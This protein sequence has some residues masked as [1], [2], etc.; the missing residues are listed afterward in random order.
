MYLGTQFIG[1]RIESEVRME[2]RDWFDVG[3]ITF[4]LLAWA[5]LVYFVPVI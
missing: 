1:T 2:M 4:W 3:L 5:S